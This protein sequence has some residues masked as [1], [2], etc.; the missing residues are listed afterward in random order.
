MDDLK[1][2]TAPSAELVNT[3]YKKRYHR[4]ANYESSPITLD[5]FSVYQICDLAC[6]SDHVVRVHKQICHEISYIVSGEGVFIRN[7]KSYEV[8]PNMVFLNSDTDIHS[9]RSSKD[10]PLRFM[11]LGFAF[12]KDHPLADREF[13]S[14]EEVIS[15]PQVVFNYDVGN[16]FQQWA[17]G[18]AMDE[19]VICQVNTA[20]AALD[21][22]DS[23]IGIAFIP[24]SCICPRD[25]VRY[26]LL[27]N[28]H[29]AI[30]MCILYDK[31]LEPSIWKFREN[32]M[33]ALQ[34]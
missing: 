18:S 3:S 21:M 31:W 17:N 4:D 22:V 5:L 7:G 32:V 10:S 29:Q 34:K 14:P 23:G 15:L 13:V 24:D 16:S 26:V 19:N 30:Y 25:N 33:S 8:C 27:K 6:A 12:H 2:I 1:R 11:C 9:I 28:W 20:Q